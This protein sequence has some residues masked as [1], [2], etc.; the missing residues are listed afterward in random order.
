MPS[1]EP[2]SAERTVPVLSEP[3]ARPG[4][5]SNAPAARGHQAHGCYQ[6]TIKKLF[7]LVNV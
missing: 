3:L 4:S 7:V 6:N 2:R 5:P 1:S